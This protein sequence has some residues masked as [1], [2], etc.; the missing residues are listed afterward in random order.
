MRK[1]TKCVHY[2]ADQYSC[3]LALD[4]VAPATTDEGHHSL[5]AANSVIEEYEQLSG[6]LFEMTSLT[7]LPEN[8]YFQ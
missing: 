2:G 6:E 3:I 4:C 8:T 1:S 7:C 5:I